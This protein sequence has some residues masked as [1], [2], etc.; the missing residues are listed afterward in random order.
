MS[1][2]TS[3][4][5]ETEHSLARERHPS[6]ELHLGSSIPAWVLRLAALACAA[7]ASVIVTGSVSTATLMLLACVVV[8]IWPGFGLPPL[9][10]AVIGWGLL[11]AEPTALAASGVVLGVHAMLV[12]TR[13]VGSVSWGAQVE[14]RALARVGAPFLVIQLLA[15]AMMH[16]A[17]AIPQGGTSMVWAGITGLAMLVALTA[18][19]VRALRR[20]T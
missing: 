7:G 1:R 17:L 9:L 18:V 15:Q 5:R 12:L 6:M 13:L 8:A 16:L 10:A 11:A 14:L 20:M 2:L 4:V 19:L 3:W